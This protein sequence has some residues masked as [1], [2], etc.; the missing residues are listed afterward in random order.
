MA[1]Q[2][3]KSVDKVAEAME[4]NHDTL[5]LT[6][7]L[8]TKVTESE[9]QRIRAYSEAQGYELSAFVRRT[10]VAAVEGKALR[11]VNVMHLELFARTVEAW[12]EMKDRFTLENF[13][14]IC[15]IVTAKSNAPLKPVSNGMEKDA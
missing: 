15:A 7:T 3:F 4:V 12:L 1:S 8:S 9:D 11:P 6:R 2:I 14:E 5:K 10:L 13:R